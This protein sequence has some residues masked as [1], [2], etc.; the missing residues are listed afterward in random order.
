VRLM[1]R[2]YR[3]K[4]LLITRL[5]R[6]CACARARARVRAQVCDA[7]ARACKGKVLR[8]AVRIGWRYGTGLDPVRVRARARARARPVRAR[9]FV[10]AR[11]RVITGFKIVSSCSLPL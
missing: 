11:A 4:P 7:R 10:N 3:I 8:D 1:K 9:A 5:I 6:T 2:L